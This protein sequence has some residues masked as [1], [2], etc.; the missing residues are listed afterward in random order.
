MKQSCTDRRKRKVVVEIINSMKRSKNETE[1]VTSI[2]K[3][4]EIISDNVSIFES[5]FN[6]NFGVFVSQLSAPMFETRIAAIDILYLIADLEPF[7]REYEFSKV[8]TLTTI[9][10]L[11]QHTEENPIDQ[12]Y[13][14]K[15]LKILN[16]I[17][18]KTDSISEE[19]TQKIIFFLSCNDSIPKGFLIYS[20]LCKTNASNIS[21][22]SMRRYFNTCKDIVKDNDNKEDVVYGIRSIAKLLQ[23]EFIDYD[24]NE[25]FCFLNEKLEEYNEVDEESCLIVAASVYILQYVKIQE[26]HASKVIGFLASNRDE[27]IKSSLLVLDK[28]QKIWKDKKDAQKMILGNTLHLLQTRIIIKKSVIKLLDCIDISIFTKEVIKELIDL[29][30]LATDF[31]ELMPILCRILDKFE[32]QQYIMDFEYDEFL[33]DISEYKEKLEEYLNENG[34]PLEFRNRVQLL[35]NAINHDDD[36]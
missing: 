13:Q 5:C 30:P 10:Q 18:K 24:E 3:I 12:D 23:Y 32:T 26:Y 19:M 34:L 6:D 36:D 27:L 28:H 31:E 17:I 4:L 25:L 7:N 8:S 14:N 33:D 15:L 11:M 35:Y 29:I 16:C 1:I 2:N 21:K 22:D 20:I 9:S